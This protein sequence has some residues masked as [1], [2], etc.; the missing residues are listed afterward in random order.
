M[1]PIL[2]FLAD[3]S[4]N[5]TREWMQAQKATYDE[6]KTIFEAFVTELLLE[7][8]IFDPSLDGLTPKDCIF[9]LHRDV[10]FSKDKSPYKTHF[11]AVL[12]EGGRKSPL[13]CY[14]LHLEPSN[15]FLAGGV[16][17]PEPALLKKLREEVDYNGAELSKIIDDSSFKAFFEGLDTQHKTSTVPRGYDKNHPYAEWLKLKSWTVTHQLKDNDLSKKDLAKQVAN[18]FRTMKPFND[19]LR[20]AQ[21][22]HK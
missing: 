12:V 18:G 6:A 8:K 17:Q 7:S 15:S 19:W 11:G 22:E 5:N 10:R 3:L 2:S 20:L 16:H 14:Y 4:Q 9:R 1:K 21:T 13:P